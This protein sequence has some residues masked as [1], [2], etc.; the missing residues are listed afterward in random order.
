M[1]AT[2]IW[3]LLC[4]SS[5]GIV[6]VLAD[7]CKQVTRC[8]TDPVSDGCRIEFDYERCDG[9]FVYSNILCNN[10]HE[11]VENCLCECASDGYSITWFDPCEGVLRQTNFLCAGCGGGGG[12]CPDYCEYCP[13]TCLGPTDYCAYPDSGCPSGWTASAGCCFEPTPILVDVESDGFN[14]TNAVS[15]VRFDFGG[16][17]HLD[18]LAWT[19]LRSDDAWLAL[20]RNGNGTIDDGGELF[21]NATRLRSGRFANNGFEALAEFDVNGDGWISAVDPVYAQLRL[22]QDANHNGLSEARELIPL[23]Q[24]AVA[25]IGVDYRE[26]RWRDEHGNE[27]R[28]LARIY[29]S[30]LSARHLW[31]VVDVILTH[32]PVP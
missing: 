30:S 21:G 12:S 19:A 4:V 29:Q 17:G 20:D 22:W 16:D 15:G 25:G 1:R 9:T 2:F 13:D 26:S 18:Q 31:V 14:L 7:D 23:V 28:Y 24:K 32:E 27:F 10:S 11:C 8:V 5:G 3:L 6:N